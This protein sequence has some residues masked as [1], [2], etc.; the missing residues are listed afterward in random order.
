MTGSH[1][2]PLAYG[3]D[4]DEVG[5]LVTKVIIDATKPLGKEF[6]PRVKPKQSLMDSFV[7]EVY[8]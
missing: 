2:D 8:L 7:L 3:E 1:L 5:T 4:R 6:A